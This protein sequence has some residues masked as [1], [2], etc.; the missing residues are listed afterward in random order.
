M[1]SP[2]QRRAIVIGCS[3]G[4]L[5]ALRTLLPELPPTY[6]LPILVV[7]HIP[8]N[9]TGL[10]TTLLNHFCQLPILEANDKDPIRPGWVHFA[11]AG[12]HL[13]VEPNETIALSIDPKVNHSRPSIDLLF[14]SAADVYQKGLIG[15]LLTGASQD[16]AQG[17]LKILHR[18]GITLVQDPKT[19]E[20]PL[21][22]RFAIAIGAAT[23]TLSLKEIGH[24][25]KQL[26]ADTR[27]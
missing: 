23:K 13:L 10:H 2:H 9:S 19:A 8:A 1:K 14:E 24:T 4:G 21:M 6:P 18:G 7:Q 3:A 27:E 5:Q 26:G 11:P 17:L 25:L 16:G 22:P 15:V 20:A 12:Y